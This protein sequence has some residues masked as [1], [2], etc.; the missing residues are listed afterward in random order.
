[1]Q[2]DHIVLFVVLREGGK[3]VA[4]PDVAG[5]LM[6]HAGDVIGGIPTVKVIARTRQGRRTLFEHAGLRVP[7]NRSIG[8]EAGG[9]GIVVSARNVS[10]GIAGV[11]AAIGIICDSEFLGFPLGIDGDCLAARSRVDTGNGGSAVLQALEVVVNLSELMASGVD[12]VD[13]LIRVVL[14]DIPILEGIARLGGIAVSGS[15]GQDV[16]IPG[17]IIGCSAASEV[18]DTLGVEH[19]IHDKVLLVAYLEVRRELVVVRHLVRH[20][21]LIICSRRRAPGLRGTR[22]I[23]NP[24]VELV[25]R[26]H[27]DLDDGAGRDRRIPID[28]IAVLTVGTRAVRPGNAREGL[29]T[30]RAVGIDGHRVLVDIEVRFECIGRTTDQCADGGENVVRGNLAARV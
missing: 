1:M 24:A 8:S 18:R 23:D 20:D 9:I 22:A 3:R 13:L 25:A 17:D 16:T 12:V 27:V 2:R 28:L 26:R 29:S 10:Q 5:R 7:V 4:I 19:V 11:I 21:A 15:S 6:R 30:V 14:V